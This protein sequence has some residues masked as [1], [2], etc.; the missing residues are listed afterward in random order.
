MADAAFF[1][2]PSERKS[3]TPLFEPSGV[4]LANCGLTHRLVV[5][6]AGLFFVAVVALSI[7]IFVG[8]LFYASSFVF[9][10]YYTSF[11]F[12]IYDPCFR[13]LF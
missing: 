3:D 12:L 6:F 8:H 2:E 13:F 7:H 11:G 4:Y 9:L 5:I 1:F 10:S